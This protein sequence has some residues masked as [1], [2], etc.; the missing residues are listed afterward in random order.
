MAG[1]M[2]ANLVE[3]SVADR[4]ATIAINRPERL[5]AVS[6]EVVVQLGDALRRFDIDAEAE[7]AILCGR[8]R[9]FSSGADVHQRQ[10]RSR[11]EFE[12]LG[13]PQGWG[14]HSADL[15][16][17]SVNWKPVIAAVHGYVL[18]L[19]LGLTLECDLIVAEEGTR[20]QLTETSRGLGASRYWALFH[21]RGAGAFGDEI[22]LT[23]RFFTAE[24]AFAARLISR[25]APAGTHIDVARELAAEIAKN[26]P[27]SVRSTIRTR[28]WYM[29][30]LTREA[31][32][33]ATPY[34]LYL[35][36][37]FQE[38]ARAFAEKRPPGAFKG[39]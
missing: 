26:P 23:G 5:N 31:Q 7:V 39:R 16:T 18:G 20:F 10:L 25:L 3:Y 21:F 33:F 9:A 13:G 8:G 12:R 22:A 15:L 2:E 19:A 11:E 29:E 14:S 30:R 32:F 28:R 36:E 4:I 38:A 37:D 35:T 27:L 24:E 1:P 6:D 34:K 17:R